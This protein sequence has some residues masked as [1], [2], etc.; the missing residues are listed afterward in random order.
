M[1][2]C[3]VAGWDESSVF[4]FLRNHW[5]DF[6]NGWTML[7]FHWSGEGSGPFPQHPCQH[8]LLFD[9]VMITLLRSVMWYL[10]V[11][12]LCTSWM[13]TLNIF[14]TTQWPFIPSFSRKKIYSEFFNHV[15]I[16]C[17]S[18]LFS[19]INSL[20]TTDSNPLFNML[21]KCVFQSVD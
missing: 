2:R 15:S 8:L 7:H 1:T 3:G 19:L 5:T 6:H 16:M 18:L 12:L 17:E 21:H 9:S 14:F 10:L 11:V 4:N 20:Y 13:I